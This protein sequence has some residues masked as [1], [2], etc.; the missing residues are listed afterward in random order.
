MLQ[1]A[2]CYTES[3][4]QHDAENPAA[5]NDYGVKAYRRRQ[6]RA[7]FA[8]SPGLWEG[9]D[10]EAERDVCRKPDSSCREYD[11]RCRDF[12]LMDWTIPLKTK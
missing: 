11:P 10:T 8:L 6:S 1:S 7:S 4:I 5:T 9:K 2:T 12:T 3:I